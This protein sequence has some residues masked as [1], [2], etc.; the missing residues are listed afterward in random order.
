MIALAD[1]SPQWFALRDPITRQ[2]PPKQLKGSGKR[3]EL[4]LIFHIKVTERKP[5]G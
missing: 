2:V 4:P 5:F 1:N 3:P